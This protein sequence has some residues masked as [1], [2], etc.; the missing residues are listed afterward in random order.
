MG[1]PG[2]QPGSSSKFLLLWPLLSLLRLLLE[3]MVS[4]GLEEM[5][6]QVGEEV[7]VATMVGTVALT[8]EVGMVALE[9]TVLEVVAVE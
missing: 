3:E 5:A 4:V 2:N 9:A 8:A 7:T 6:T 1:N